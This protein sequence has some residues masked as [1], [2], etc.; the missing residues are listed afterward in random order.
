LASMAQQGLLGLDFIHSCHQL[1]RDLK[2][3]NMLIDH[4]GVVKVSDFGIMRQMD[5][6]GGMM[7]VGEGD[8]DA[9]GTDGDEDDLIPRAKTFVG[10][11]S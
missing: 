9:L 5:P 11:V 4:A 6:T 2:P 10:T 3:A 7:P 8:E 1:H